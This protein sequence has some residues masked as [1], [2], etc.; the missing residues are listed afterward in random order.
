MPRAFW[1]PGSGGRAWLSPE[2]PKASITSNTTFRMEIPWVIRRAL[3]R[4][5]IP[6]DRLYKRAFTSLY[7]ASISAIKAEESSSLPSLSVYVTHTF[8]APLQQPG[9]VLQLS[10]KKEAD[11]QWRNFGRIGYVKR[12]SS[13]GVR[14]RDS[15]EELEPLASG[16]RL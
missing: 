10:T 13:R 6:N 7:A 16:P 8:A 9:C 5:S 2:S 12:C 14:A 11:V 15:E 4:L 1:R 3:R